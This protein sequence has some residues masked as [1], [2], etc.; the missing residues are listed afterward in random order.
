MRAN[1]NNASLLCSAQINA[2]NCCFFFLWTWTLDPLLTLIPDQINENENKRK[3]RNE[4]NKMQK[5][6]TYF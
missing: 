1:N 3:E 5:N 6:Q 2:F 4:Q